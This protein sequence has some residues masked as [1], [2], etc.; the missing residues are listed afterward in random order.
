MGA[1]G[2]EEQHVTAQV[3]AEALLQKTQVVIVTG[4]V[5]PVFIFNLQRTEG[6]IS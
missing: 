6:G 5:A 2:G 1:I 4:K 3:V